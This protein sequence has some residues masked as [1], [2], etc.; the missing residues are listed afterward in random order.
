ME[1]KAQGQASMSFND[2]ERQRIKTLVGGF[3]EGG[4]HDHQRCQIK[5]LYEVHGYDVEIIESR[6]FSIGSQLWAENPIAKF[7][8]DPDTLG[9]QLYSM[10]AT[11]NWEKYPE[12]EPTNN[13]RSLIKEIEKD[14]SRVFWG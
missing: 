14:P 9:W 4:I 13:L 12:K 5:V 11:G 8:Y 10:R 3:C 7:Q 6:P 1:I 2:I